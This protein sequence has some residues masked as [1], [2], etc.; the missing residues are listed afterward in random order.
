MNCP[1]EENT[2]LKSVYK[3]STNFAAIRLRIRNN[4]V[5]SV[6]IVTSGD[7]AIA[8]LLDQ[9]HSGTPVEGADGRQMLKATL[10]DSA[11][12]KRVE[13]FSRLVRHS[14]VTPRTGHSHKP[15]LAAKG[16][17]G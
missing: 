15:N 5:V 2:E 13:D 9:I 7:S 12:R 8:D 17:M 11:L 4:F 3:S 14:A 16:E 1:L 10:N 6:Y